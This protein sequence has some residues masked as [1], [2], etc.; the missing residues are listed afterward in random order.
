MR[1]SFTR[2]ISIFMLIAAFVSQGF[3]V[4]VVTSFPD[5]VLSGDHANLKKTEAFVLT[6]TEKVV[7]GTGV[8]RLKNQAGT[9]TLA[10]YQATNSNVSITEADG[11]WKISVNFTSFLVEGT[12]YILDADANFV[13]AADD[14]Q[15]SN[16]DDWAVTMGDYTN[17]LLAGTPFLPANNGTSV[18][19]DQN[20]TATFNEPI[21]IA[22]GGQVFIY[23]DNGT[24]HGDL[25]DVVAVGSG[26]SA[27]GAV[28]TINPNK[29]FTQLTKYY[30]VIPNGVVTDASVNQNKFAGWLNNT[31]WAFT[32]RDATAPVVTKFVKDNVGATAFDIFLQLDKKGKAFVM[33]VGSGQTPD[34]AMF[35]SGN[36]MKEAN[37]TAASTDVKVSLT[38]FLNVGTGVATFV[39]GGTYDVWV[40]TENSE[41]P[42]T[43]GDPVKKLTVTT[44]DVTKPVASVLYPA[45]G[46]GAATVNTKNY[47][48]IK[49]SE[50]VKLGTG[51][52]DIYTWNNSLNH[53]L[54]V[55]VP[56]ASCKISLLAGVTENDSLYIPVNK[57]TWVSQATYFV[58]YNEGIVTDVAGNKLAAKTTTGDWKFTVKDFKAPTY[59]VTPANGVTNA[60]N[61]APQITITFNEDLYSNATGTA[62]VIGDIVS[63]KISLK[64]GTSAV[65][66][67]VHSFNGKVIQLTID[68]AAV[69]SNA[70]FELSI[71]TKLFFDASGNKGT[72]VDKIN[73]TLKDFEG[74]EVT[75]EP[76]APGKSDNILVKFNE[77]V[78]NADGSAITN[79]NVAGMVIFRKGTDAT[80]A[81]VS[82][83]YT[84]ASDAKS[85]IID[86]ANDFTTPGDQYYVRLGA[87]AVKDAAGNPNALKE[88]V[89][90]V[91]DF[92]V[93]TAT[94]SGIGTSPVSPT[95]LSAVITF[96]EPMATLDG[97]AVIA[98]DVATELITIKENGENISFTAEWT[99]TTAIAITATY[100]YNKNYTISIGKS[101]KDLAGNAFE[102]V[103]KSFTTWSD[104]A[105]AMVSVSP[106]N[107]ATQQ[108]NNVAI[109]VTFDQNISLVASPAI[110][111]SG[112]ISGAS[113]VTTAVAGAKLTIGHSAFV[114]N[115]TV[116]VTIPAGDVIGANG[117]ATIT[118]TS[119]TFKTKDTVAPTV[120]TYSPA[121]A[122]TNAPLTG[123]LTLTFSENVVKKVGQILIK[124]FDSDV[125]V[126]ALT[127]ANAAVVTNTKLEVTLASSL[128]YN[129]KYYVVVTEGVVEDAA[130]NKYAG[131]SGNSWYFTTVATPGAFEVASSV[132]AHNADKIAAGITSITVTFN[133]DIKAGSLSSVNKITLN[134]GTANVITDV[135]NSSRF[136]I[137]GNTLTINTLSDIVASKT[138]T[139]TL[140]AD[141]VK[142]S[143]NTPNT[144]KTITF[145]TFDNNGPKVVSTTP[146]AGATGVPTNTTISVTWDETPLYDGATISAATIKEHS[147]VTVNGGNAYTATVN[148]LQWVLT[149]DAPLAEKVTYPVVVKQTAVADANG[150]TQGADYMWQFTTIDATCN[151]PTVFN[152]TENTKGTEVKFTVNF[153]EK[154]T[155]YYAV[156]PSAT[157]APSAA[158]IIALNKAISFTNDAGGTSAA[159]TV[160][161]LTS[162][163]AYKAYF[164]AVDASA[165]QSTIYA[166]SEFT[167]ADV[168]APV[169]TAMVPANGATAVAANTTLKLTFNEAVLKGAGAFV[170]REVA[171]DVL[172]AT[173]DVSGAAVTLSSDSKTATIVTGVTLAS[174]KA[175]YV[176][177]STGAFTDAALNKVA[178]ISG[179][180]TWAFTTKDTEAPELVETTPDYDEAAPEILAGTTLSMKFSEAMKIGTGVVYV[181]YLSGDEAGDV[182]EVINASALTL[183]ADKKTISFSMTHVPVEQ[184]T[185]YVDLGDL[186]LTDEA[187]NPWAETILDPTVWDFMIKDQTAPVLT[188]SIPANN[189]TGIAINSTIKLT[190]SENIFK[191]PDA[192]A[193]DNTTIKTVLSLKDAAGA[194]VAFNATIAG[195]VV[196]ITPTANLKSETTYK[197]TVSPVVDNRKNVSNEI[198]VTFTTKDMTAPTV[199][200]NPSFDTTFNPKTGVV[201]VTFSEPIYDDVVNTNESNPVIVDV[202]AA[203]IPSFFTYNAGTITRDD[204]GD[205]ATFAVGTVVPFTGAIS[206]DKKVITLTPAASAVPLASE[207]WYKVVL[208]AGVVEDAAENSN[209]KDSTIFQ[210]EDHVKPEVASTEG[211]FEFTPMG[212]TAEDAAM[213]ITFNEDVKLGAGNVYIRNKVNGEVVETIAISETT[214]SVEGNVVTIEHADFPAAMNFFVTADAGTFTDASANANPWV[215]IATSAIDT[216]NF[217]TADAVAP[218]VVAEGG[219]F[220]APG[221]VNVP[222]NTALKITFDKKIAANDD[223]VK[224]WVVIYNEDWTPFQVIEVLNGT[225]LTIGSITDPV[226][227]SDRVVSITHNLLVQNSKYYVRVTKGLVKDEAG[228]L[229]AGIADDTWSFTTEDNTAP[230]IVA[231]TPVDDATAVSAYTDLTI[232]FDRN[233]LANAAGK[234]K[235]YKEVPGVALGTLIET[236][237]PTSA[238][239]VIDGKIATVALAQPLAYQ[240]G[241]YVIV[242]AGS[243][244]NT[245]TSKIPLDP[246]ITTTQGWNFTTGGDVDAPMLLT[247]TPN[248]ETIADNHPTFVM[249]FNEAVALTTAGGKLK[250]TAKDATTAIL[251][252]DLAAGMISTDGKTVTVTY[253]Y[254]ATSGGL[255]KNTDY[256]VTVDAGALK[257]AAGNVF[258]GVTANTTWTFK[259]GADFATDVPDPINGSLEFTV[260]PNP[261][262]GYVNVTGADKLSRI[263]LTNVAGQRVKEIVNPTETIQTS[264]LRSGLYFITLVTK[265]GVVAKTERIVK[266]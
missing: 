114:E 153:N 126:Q 189:A 13:K 225:N 11:V 200:W 152:L 73:F 148:G 210:I 95:G 84:V 132:P 178:G 259:T 19:L 42:A 110:T 238:S 219:L 190:F 209:L 116:T 212:P 113:T 218:G 111:V 191:S 174:E 252:I 236:I 175:Y 24:A 46:E 58:K 76:L 63:P 89:I 188:S 66:Y 207:A 35:T 240:T 254:S 131:I 34:A 28:L 182:F 194:S 98:T 140:E 143:F 65:D 170:I 195:N 177:V 193:F 50:K 185:F 266:K 48:T 87:G 85:F 112:S 181:K 41:D 2:L 115:E 78:F 107:N 88:Q 243:F 141:I 92:I 144:A 75:I 176:E 206:A 7:A 18:Q 1:K 117:I 122:A 77:P 127:E 125:T 101:L 139:L 36:G 149:L 30:V 222:L 53:E 79:A 180:T 196:V 138:Y 16:A 51:S 124:D 257:D 4:G 248:M 83:T 215:G 217:S 158:E 108:A 64:K 199:V 129:K 96:S 49:L 135:A 234:I 147:L 145:Y 119:W 91:A 224:R 260:Y 86:P 233:V 187:N 100:G 172:V 265:D 264:D 239:V 97:T 228:N 39:E 52:V 159:Q 164:V 167:T 160:T 68:P 55:S 134:D 205:I 103:S 229:F 105:P 128:A 14:G 253:V 136:S 44:S 198:T 150:K 241:Y 214:A 26:L 157:N 208:K 162:G 118:A 173:V 15:A 184:T 232:E 94:F 262:D 21:A 211:G 59:V 242:E 256:F 8:I 130:G 221:S 250:V 154:G 27:A 249:T 163:A 237:D 109:E 40:Y 213:T 69:T 203:N 226:L 230:T 123:K 38:Q 5:L 133:R 161:G 169:V 220:P 80:G 245:S 60:N 20:L 227:Q 67:S 146:V 155:V 246:G 179:S 165:N 151:A 62:M 263:I 32:T 186:V 81:I 235:L 261:F 192:T 47:L 156:L 102:G 99:S 247:W 171:T 71:D 57:S 23:K 12:S 43:V 10:A 202:V 74:P 33:A 204:D 251:N 72:T 54:F 22:E 93:P 197:V 142:D 45:N 25:F 201:T 104:V 258:G 255:N 137:S 183:S 70:S 29:D 82:A 120:T 37:V 17:P 216:W 231:L 244:T 223:N 168:V 56:V 31:T 9:T 121:I 106:A 90:I 3:A 6:S 166:P 61:A